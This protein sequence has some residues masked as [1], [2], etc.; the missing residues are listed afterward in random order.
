M[1]IY[2]YAIR[3]AL[4]SCLAV[5]IIFSTASVSYSQRSAVGVP[6]VH[7]NSAGVRS[8]GFLGQQ[9]LHM[10]GPVQGYYQPV[11]ITGPRGVN[12]SMTYQGEFLQNN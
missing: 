1:N 2:S 7:Y 4:S 9:R 5:L 6:P 12:I 11:L 8:P 3:R 10:G